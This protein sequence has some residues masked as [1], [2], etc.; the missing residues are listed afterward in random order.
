MS[1]SAGALPVAN[2]RSRTSLSPP[3]SS[4]N[5][6][7]TNS[8]SGSPTKLTATNSNTV[9]ASPDGVADLEP[10]RGAVPMTRS[11]SVSIIYSVGVIII[12]NIS[13]DLCCYKITYPSITHITYARTLLLHVHLHKTL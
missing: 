9:F 3:L 12:G 7:V 4:N 6:S 10:L 8:Q 11:S 13:L 2:L 1:N 5:H